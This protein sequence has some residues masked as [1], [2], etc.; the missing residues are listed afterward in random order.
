M[1]KLSALVGL[2]LLAGC[3]KF[4]FGVPALDYE[5]VTRTQCLTTMA[6]NVYISR[7]NYWMNTGKIIDVRF[8]RDRQSVL[9][10]P[11]E[12]FVMY[13]EIRKEGN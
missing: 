11:G 6:D 9:F 2:I 12:D 4:E 7:E 13:R 8:S 10:V 5:V 3:G 1:R